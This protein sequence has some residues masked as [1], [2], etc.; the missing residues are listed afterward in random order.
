M[1]ACFFLVFDDIFLAQVILTFALIF[2]YYYIAVQVEL[3][4]QT[5]KW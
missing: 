4:I 2:T 1:V 5:P 3:Y